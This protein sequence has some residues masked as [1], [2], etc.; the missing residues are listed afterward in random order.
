MHGYGPG[1][2]GSALPDGRKVDLTI[3]RAQ[4]NGGTSP[5]R[6]LKWNR[7]G[8]T[9]PGVGGTE[10][11][12]LPDGSFENCAYPEQHRSSGSISY[13]EVTQQYLL[14]FVCDSQGDPANGK[15]GGKFG[16]AWFYSTSY[17]LSNM[18]QWTTPQEIIGSWSKWDN[19]HGCPD[20][21]GW[22]PTFMSLGAKPG[23]LST[24][25]YVFYLWGCLGGAGDNVPPNRQFSAR[26]FTIT[27][28]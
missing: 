18:R 23:H 15:A 13:V 5:L 24:S 26:A 14:T 11:Q 27:I 17:D 12:I 7:T 21:K 25:G 16:S 22:Y 3:A 10:T 6:F 9:E 4:L 19:S 8:F 2:T 1:V 20:Y 28:H